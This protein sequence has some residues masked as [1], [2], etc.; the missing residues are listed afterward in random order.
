MNNKSTIKRIVNCFLCW[1]FGCK[2]DNEN[3]VFDT[4]E[5]SYGWRTP[6]MRCH[7]TDVDYADLVGDTKYN[8]FKTWFNYYLYRKWWPE[9]CVD[10]GHRYKCD[11]NIMHDTIPF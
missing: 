1:W 3:A 10:C 2:P 11:E 9:K 8:R 6:C 5:Y 7:I 4:D